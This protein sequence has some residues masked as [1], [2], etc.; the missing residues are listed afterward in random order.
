MRQNRSSRAAGRRAIAAAAFDR[1]ARTP[2]F[3]LLRQ[4]C[5]YDRTRGQAA[6]HLA[7]T[8]SLHRSWL[9]E[10]YFWPIGGRRHGLHRLLGRSQAFAIGNATNWRDKARR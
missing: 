3:R 5:E 7:R 4:D 2:A 9:T 1:G 8:T 10:P 6:V